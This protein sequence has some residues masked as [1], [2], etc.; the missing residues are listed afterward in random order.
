MARVGWSR[1]QV[2]VL[3]LLLSGCTEPVRTSGTLQELLAKAH[4]LEKQGK[5]EDA[6]R[7]YLDVPGAE[8][9][10]GRV[11]RRDPRRFLKHDLRV[12]ATVNRP[13]TLLVRGE[14]LLATGDRDSALACYRG[15]VAAIATRL[16]PGWE[17]GKVPFGYYPVEF[18]Y[19][20]DTADFDA[21]WP[22]GRFHVGPGSHRDNWLVR[23]FIELQAWPEAAAELARIWAQHRDR[24]RWGPDDGSS[25]QFAIDYA[26]FLKLRGDTA[27]GRQV[28]LA[29]VSK[30]DFEQYHAMWD[31]WLLDHGGSNRGQAIEIAYEYFR[32]GGH[33]SELTDGL[34]QAIAAGSLPARRVLAR[35]QRLAGM[36]DEAA[37]LE[38]DYLQ[39][40]ELDPLSSAYRLGLVHEELQQPAQ[41]AV[42]FERALALPFVQ[43]TP[44]PSDEGPNLANMERGER[45]LGESLP[46]RRA[47]FQ[48]DVLERLARLHAVLGRGDAT[49]P[50]FLRELDANYALRVNATL[51]AH[52]ARLYKDAGKEETF[53]QWVRQHVNQRP[54]SE[55][56]AV[57]LWAA[58][59]KQRAE[60][61]ALE[62]ARSGKL[63]DLDAWKRS[64][65]T[66]DKN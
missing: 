41:A 4:N 10:A 31:G 14:A 61:M 40:S 52:V 6:L 58:G 32:E 25:L 55:G 34:A 13:R 56:S 30:I 12:A 19:S 50:I 7:I 54:G 24:A 37:R 43:P 26:R 42:Q 39:Y 8:Y 1:A 51:V 65:S 2:G 66:L 53:Q 18:V 47:K 36:P 63:A 62:A 59:E 48:A 64:L 46:I 28:L 38:A 45:F 57:L 44:P 11:A 35:I 27:T 60:A 16:G 21:E 22:L 33:E 3:A 23:R 17:M 9:A 20:Y 49:L 5:L 15:F 29:A